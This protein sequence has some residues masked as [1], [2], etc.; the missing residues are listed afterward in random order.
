MKLDMDNLGGVHGVFAWLSRNRMAPKFGSMPIG[1]YQQDTIN[2]M[3]ALEDVFG[4]GADLRVKKGYVTD[5]RTEVSVNDVEREARKRSM[6]F[7]YRDDKSAREVWRH[8]V[9]VHARTR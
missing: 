5:G 6:D 4:P 9:T 7:K 2:A 3:D 8:R 1:Y